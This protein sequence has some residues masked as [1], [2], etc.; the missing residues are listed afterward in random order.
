MTA[1]ER[2]PPTPEEIALLNARMKA[3][4]VRKIIIAALLAGLV[5]IVAARNDGYAVLIGSQTP[6]PA[7]DVK[8]LTRLDCTYFTGTE[9]VISHVW[10]KTEE[11]KDGCPWVNKVGKAAP[12]VPGPNDVGAP[13][14]V[15]PLPS[16]PLAAPSAPAP[17]V[18]AQ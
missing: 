3:H 14:I 15:I 17:A 5:G 12:M 16:A 4:G 11:A 18:P 8:N 7:A 13:D 6:P 9:R 1:A 10:R 2:K